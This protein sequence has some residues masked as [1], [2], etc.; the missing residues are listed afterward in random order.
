MEQ[1]IEH[2]VQTIRERYS[3]PLSLDELAH[4]AMVSKFHFLRTFR[5]ITGVTP[6]RF[7]TAVRL[8]E[9]KRL[10]LTTAL[11]VSDVSM[12]VGYSSTGS[13]TRRFTESVGCS[14]TRYRRTGGTHLTHD[15][16]TPERHVL[17][18]AGADGGTITGS[19]QGEA[20]VSAIY[21]GLFERPILERC[22]G[23]RALIT[24]PGPFRL[25]QV[26]AGTW[27]VHAVA[28]TNRAVPAEYP[29]ERPLLAD[30]TGPIEVTPGASSHVCLTVRPL[31][32]S[33]PPVL[34]VLPELN[35]LGVAA[36][37]RC[38]TR[39]TQAVAQGAGR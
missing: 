30:T 33:Q 2:A 22:P 21:V 31:R 10:L 39:V 15:A 16:H 18:P 37:G 38:A 1:V 7:L 9:A 12:Q 8:Q 32:W 24:E 28:R 34:L 3:E 11:N 14:P 17:T 35:A 27:Y 13:F 36:A 6:G 5:R 4:N 23:L 19:V 20:G 26:P 29:G 25:T